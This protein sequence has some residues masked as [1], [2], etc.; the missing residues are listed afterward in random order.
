M[1]INLTPAVRHSKPPAL[2]TSL[3]CSVTVTMQTQDTQ[4]GISYVTAFPSVLGNEKLMRDRWILGAP[5]NMWHTLVS[6]AGEA[7]SWYLWEKTLWGGEGV[8]LRLGAP[9]E[10]HR[11]CAWWGLQTVNP[12]TTSVHCAFLTVSCFAFDSEAFMS[13]GVLHVYFQMLHN[14]KYTFI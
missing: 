14:L 13:E 11:R 3:S 10:V 7:P 2:F 6:S 5:L 8:G 12:S 1:W 4:T 9:A